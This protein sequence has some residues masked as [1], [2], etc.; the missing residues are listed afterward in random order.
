MKL[1]EG[2]EIGALLKSMDCLGGPVRR[3]NIH[4]CGLAQIS[5][6]AWYFRAIMCLV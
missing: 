5:F 1:L 6:P 4:A 2:I 3:R